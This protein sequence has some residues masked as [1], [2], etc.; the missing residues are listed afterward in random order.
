MDN[1]LKKT[2]FFTENLNMKFVI[3]LIVLNI[4]FIAKFAGGEDHKLATPL[5]AKLLLTSN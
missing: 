3:V 2:G 4:M 1:T 5:T